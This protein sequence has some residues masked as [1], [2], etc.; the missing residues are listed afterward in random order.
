M[1]R[2]LEPRRSSPALV[3]DLLVSLM[4]LFLRPPRHASDTVDHV[5]PCVGQVRPRSPRQNDGKQV[6][7]R[8]P[9]NKQVVPVCDYGLATIYSWM[10]IPI[11]LP[12][13]QQLSR[14][15]YHLIFVP[16]WHPS[17]SS[18]PS[19]PQMAPSPTPGCRQCP[20]WTRPCSELVPSP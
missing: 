12:I 14:A 9:R 8:P 4:R 6:R 20:A 7:R 19:P 5:V 1:W 2:R 3:T 16:K 15:Y 18:S 10:I 11:L 13:D 17:R